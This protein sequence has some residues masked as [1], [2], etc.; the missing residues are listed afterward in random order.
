MNQISE[1]ERRRNNLRTV[2]VIIIIGT[3]PFYCVGIVLYLAAPRG[4]VRATI[5]PFPTN[6]PLDAS[7]LTLMPTQTQPAIIVSNTPLGGGGIINPFPPTQNVFQPPIIPP[8]VIFFPTSVIFPTLTLAPT[9]TFVPAATNTPLPTLTPLPLPSATLFPS[10][11]P[12]PTNTPLPTQTPIPTQTATP[13]PTPT[14]T[15]TVGVFDTPIP[16]D[17]PLPP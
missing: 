11:T 14:P 13:T 5:T 15:E 7:V 3:L 12:I 6:T 4:D 10:N 17:T 8:T 1:I 16:F 2:L 9:L